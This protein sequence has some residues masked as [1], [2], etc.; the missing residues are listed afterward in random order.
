[1]IFGG[2]GFVGRHLAPWLAAN[3]WT[4]RVASRHPE[5]HGPSRS[6][7][8]ILAVAADLQDED[9]VRGAVRDADAVVNLVG[10]GRERGQ[11]F[12]AVH[13][14]GAARIEARSLGKG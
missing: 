5:H 10:I 12:K 13:V 7:T 3:G 11:R 4:V 9:Q 8:H 2:S 6:D 1:M 14:E